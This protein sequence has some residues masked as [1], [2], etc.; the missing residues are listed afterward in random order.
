MNR[1]RKILTLLEAKPR[2]Y[3]SEQSLDLQ[4]GPS[5][6]NLNE[7]L[8]AAPAVVFRLLARLENQVIIFGLVPISPFMVYHHLSACN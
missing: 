4:L 7:T 2:Q 6:P 5:L 1:G 8:S 3:D